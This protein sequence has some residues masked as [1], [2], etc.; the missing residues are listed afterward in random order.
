MGFKISKEDFKV[1]M[2]I[3]PKIAW[4]FHSL[5]NMKTTKKLLENNIITIHG[6]TDEELEDDIDTSKFSFLDV[7]NKFYKD[8]NSIDDIN[9]EKAIKDFES[10]PE[11]ATLVPNN[12]SVEDGYLVGQAAIDYFKYKLIEE[13]NKNKTDFSYKD[14]SEFSFEKSVILSKETLADNKIK[15]LF[16]PSFEYDNNSYK[17]KCDVLI[18]NGNNHVVIIEFKASTKSKLEYFYDVLY[19]KYVLEKNGYIVDD[20][21]VGLINPN[22]IRG[23]FENKTDLS[24]SFDI[25][26]DE[27]PD[28]ESEIEPFMDSFTLQDEK[29]SDIEYNKLIKIVSFLENTKVHPDFKSLINNI[30]NDTTNFNLEKIFSEMKRNFTNESFLM[31]ND[32]YSPK[33]NYK[34]LSCSWVNK[35]CHHV[36]DYYDKNDYSIYDFSTFKSKAAKLYSEFGDEVN[37]MNIKDP[38]SDYYY[39]DNKEVF[40]QDQIRLINVIKSYIK[41]NKTDTSCF[42]DRD[43]LFEISEL[44]NEYRYNEIYMYDFETVKWAIPKYNN[45]WS[46]QQIPFQYSMHSFLISDFDYRTGK[47]IKHKNFIADKQKDPRPEFWT[48]FI[49]D[50]FE[51]GPGVYVA[52]NKAFEKTVIKN[53]IMTYPSLAKPLKY[54]YANTIDLMEF[55]KKSKNN[56]LIYHPNFKGSYSIKKTQPALAPELSYKDLVINKGDVASKIFR[57]YLDN[58][59]SQDEY[60]TMLR[61]YMLKYCDRDTLAMVALLQSI[62]E[63]INKHC[64]FEKGILK[65]KK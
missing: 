31:K 25:Y 44:L 46:Y 17:V 8:K 11:F 21:R 58:I 34:T 23:S 54:I 64:I 63:L 30:F 27:C 16:E 20:V 42:I 39:I 47:G 40:K 61:P 7:F 10:D 24:E 43:R 36:V 60:E 50:C 51:F 57:Q 2:N 33:I 49:K 6:V 52:Y 45:S 9:I 55:F 4:I 1:Y 48:N 32:C 3:C 35:V 13:N 53:A 26:K 15:Y 37:I 14:F 62:L 59:I 28:Y 29:T 19:Q 41:S 12:D 65:W 56:W 5:D 18:N 22:Y 38:S